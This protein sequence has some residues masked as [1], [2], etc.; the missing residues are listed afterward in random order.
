MRTC[1]PLVPLS[2]RAA[3]LMFL[4]FI[5]TVAYA[6]FTPSDDAYI[7]SAAPTTNYGA[8]KPL[9][10]SS[11]A[12][13][14]FIRFDLTAVPSGYTGA[15]IAKATLKL[16]VDTCTK[17][18]SF[19]VD[20]V[21]GT[22]TEKTITYSLQPAL[23]ATIAASV[24]LVTTNKLD[25]VE[26]DVTPAV[27]DWLNGT[28]NDGI[29]LVANSPLVATFDS[30]EATTTSHPPELDI[31]FASSAG[32]GTIT[33]V[34]TGAGSGLTGGG[35][36]GTLNL[37]LTNTCAANQIL[38][39]TGTAWVCASPSGGGS[40]TSVGLTAPSTDFLV[41]GSPVTT[42]GTLGLGWLV[43]PDFNDTPNA[44]VKRD[45]N[46]N[47]S[48]GAINA[49]NSFNLAGNVFD[50]GN[51]A[52]F[53]AFTGFAGNGAM[54]GSSNTATGYQAMVADTTGMGNTAIGTYTLFSNTTGSYNV[55]FGGG[56]LYA[57]VAGNR[58]TAT[59]GRALY[60]ATTSDNT[61][62]GHAALYSTTTGGSNTA[63]GSQAMYYNT[64]GSFNTALGYDA[65]FDQTYTGLTNATAIGA[66]SDV[67][68][69]NSLVL[70]S[71][72]GVNGATANTSV[73]IGTTSPL[74]TLDV[75]GTGNFTGLVNFA[76][77][78]QFPGSGTITGVTAGSGLTGGG[79]SGNVTL[80]LAANECPLGD[81]L[82]ALPFSCSPFASLGANTFSGSQEVNGFL[83]TTGMVSASSYQIGSYLFAS[84]SYLTQNAFLGF[85]GNTT[86][87]GQGNTGIGSAA[88]LS[89]GAGYYNTATG[90]NALSSNTSGAQNTA[91]GYFA[92]AGNTLGVG[93]TA[94]A[95]YAL[96][97]NTGDQ[98]GNGS[99]NTALG[100][101]ALQDNTLGNA[102]TGIG[103][104]ALLSNQTGGAN[105]GVGISA[106]YYSQT[107]SNNT[108]V[109][110]S[111]F[112]HNKT[113]SSLT[114]IGYECDVSADGLTN[115]TAVGAL[116][117]VGEN[118]ALVLGSINGVNG[119]TANTTVGIGTTTPN[120]NYLLDVEGNVYVKNLTKGGGSFKIDHPLDPANKY[121]YHSFVESP[122]MMNIYNG[123]VVTDDT[124]VAAVSLPDW[125]EALN[126][127][128]RYQLTVIGQFAQ[129]IVASEISNNQFTI[130][131]DKPNVKVSWQVT[132][133]RQDAYANA[134]RIPVEE[135]KKPKERGHYLHPE[136]FGATERQAIGSH[137]NS[138]NQSK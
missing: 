15:S 69:S 60:S 73:G 46:G 80:G 32:G 98:N 93:N 34:L 123:N 82:T 95:T 43:A 134:Y 117:V 67:T 5:A 6:Q 132:G 100:Q 70:G 8:A 64:T 114:C 33:G 89:N 18:G 126:R 36:S 106:L 20:L 91:S 75:H 76:S 102:N 7:N 27:V 47:F 24:P 3:V 16:Y 96:V 65:A 131:T 19:N 44:I 111:A 72:N 4:L 61:A 127:D 99:V 109:G 136:L 40:V 54:T 113:G 25:Y 81:A 39:W 30:K 63:V 41:T 137:S 77:G 26:V 23:G 38:Q 21:N 57:N 94:T 45:G 121:L 29:A 135:E 107:G 101:R 22:W 124:G 9:D 133:I 120:M 31:V 78:Q 17:A 68:Q 122:D 66:N 116:A 35:T 11:A 112:P 90:D 115:A 37:S 49:A 103:V 58:N 51:Y 129:A 79:T 86:T 118:N 12:D 42:S 97:N 10:L 52:L 110:A 71:I 53:N 59:G 83:S 128:F 50:Q 105:T 125:F 48:A 130:R 108:A 28:A 74:Y 92:L 138:A 1:I 56:S 88:L 87:T 119:A 84:G 85:A 2:R 104:Q 13:T 14:A 62:D 55:G